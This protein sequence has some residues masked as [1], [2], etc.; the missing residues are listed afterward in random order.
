LQDPFESNNNHAKLS[1]NTSSLVAV[2]YAKNN[3]TRDV[4]YT[5]HECSNLV[6]NNKMVNAEEA[7]DSV[8]VEGIK[9]LKEVSSYI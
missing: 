5:I 9:T 3:I 7:E 6:A 8:V 4:N 2:R 1:D